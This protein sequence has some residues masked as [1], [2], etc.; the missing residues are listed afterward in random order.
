MFCGDHVVPPSDEEFHQLVWDFDRGVLEQSRLSITEN[1]RKT[2]PYQTGPEENGAV[3]VGEPHVERVLEGVYD[4][5]SDDEFVI[6]P[7][8]VEAL[9][10]PL[11]CYFSFLHFVSSFLSRALC[12]ACVVFFF[13][14]CNSPVQSLLFFIGN[15]METEDIIKH[16]RTLD[17]F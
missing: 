15:M 10:E 14:V 17:P 5:D 13:C 12:W 11:L 8:L 6:A 9:K 2:L 4:R 16:L 1:L 3:G 7:E